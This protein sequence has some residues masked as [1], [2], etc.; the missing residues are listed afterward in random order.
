[1]WG[2]RF[3]E[4]LAPELLAYTASFSIDRR[5]LR[6]DVIGSI[7]HAR[8][9]QD[10]AVI[11]AGDADTIV[12]GLAGIL[13]DVEAG[14]LELGG[15]HEDV[16]SFLEATLFER[17]GPAAGRLHTGR[18]R[19]DQVATA[20][21]LWVKEHT[22]GLVAETHALAARIGDR[23]GATLD[24]IL[25]GFTHLQHAQP[26]R[27]AH[28][29]LAYA[30]MLVRDIGRLRAAYDAADALPLGSGAIAGSG[31]P[32]DRHRTASRLGFTRLS[33]NSI[34]AVGDRD[35]AV[36][37]AFA[38]ALLITHLSRWAGELVLWATDEFGFVRLSDRVAT[39][40]SLMPQKKNP[41][42]AEL[43][44][45]KAARAAGQ[46]TTLLALLKGL[47]AGYHLDLQEDKAAVFDVFDTVRASL[48]A[49]SAFLEG[50][51]FN[52]GRM[53][54]AARRGWLTAT[55]AADYLVRRGVPF[56]EAH[57]AAGRVVRVAA[58]RDVPLWELPV[59]TYR[60]VHP[61]FDE[62][63]LQAVRLEAAVESKLVPGGTARGAVIDQLRALRETLRD[64]D[65]WQGQ[66][67][68]SLRT[69]TRLLTE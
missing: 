33:E 4:P 29:L 32:L 3:S 56:R 5:L 42:T 13:R 18:S 40:S 53:H 27:L 44:R 2:G 6:W 63:V 49:M 64:V 25:P 38:A 60:A 12:R 68:E 22:A 54:D 8:A 1:M 50:V 30:W 20:F 58:D 28:H 46:V 43:I 61:A 35:F 19:N 57:E 67:S 55:E 47:P 48:Q 16:H 10:A 9:L 26:V 59:E 14:T 7:A 62:D 17:I 31:F 34:D 66:A 15:R 11:D 45:G 52:A 65:A 69:A 41:D 51:E 36:E 39:G 24:I 37:A 21:R 23:A